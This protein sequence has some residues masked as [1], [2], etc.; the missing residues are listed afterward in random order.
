M[1]GRARVACPIGSEDFAAAGGEEDE[2]Q[3][4]NRQRCVGW[5]GRAATGGWRADSMSVN[6]ILFF[7]LRW[8][9]GEPRTPDHLKEASSLLPIK[10]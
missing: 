9:V 5:S 1:V 8:G 10:F 2:T 3:K 7:T 6:R 4:M